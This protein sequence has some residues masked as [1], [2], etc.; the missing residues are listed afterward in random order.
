MDD[1]HLSVSLTQQSFAEIFEILIQQACIV[2]LP[3]T[4]QDYLSIQHLMKKCL[5]PIEMLYAYNINLQL[6][7]SLVGSYYAMPDLSMV[8]LLL[9]Q[10]QS[11]PSPGHI[12]A[13]C[14]VYLA[15]TKT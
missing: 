14:N 1:S 6:V 10:H 13:A 11:N 9:A 5:P 12:E 8:V 7:L 4:V 2:I 15:N 3:L